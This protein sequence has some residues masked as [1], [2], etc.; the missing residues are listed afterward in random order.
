MLL[1]LPYLTLDGINE[2]GVVISGQNVAGEWVHDPNKI[3]LTA[4]EIR[5]LVLDHAR[6][7]NEA[8][9]LIRQYNN[10]SCEGNKLLVSDA[11]G[12]SAII[13]YFNG[14]VNVIRSQE[15]WQVSTNFLVKYEPPDSV[16]DRC[17]RYSNAYLALQGYNG[18]IT[19]PIAMDILSS[20]YN[21][22]QRSAVYNQTTGKV[23]LCVGGKYGQLH[24]LR[25]PLIVDLAVVKTKVS[26]DNV[27]VGGHMSLA[28]KVV[29]RS[30]RPSRATKVRFYVS[31]KRKLNAQA[32]L[33]GTSKLSS[34]TYRKKETVRLSIDLPEQITAGKYFLI[35]CVDESG[36]NNDPNPENNI[37]ILTD[38]ILVY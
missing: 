5:R 2:Y 27:S 4:L 21:Y 15:P 16:L 37:F 31:K 3:S 20:V 26:D 30:P 35:I 6:D 11:Y 12:N 28:A 14:Q 29:N 8:V 17:W 33:I 23:T 19:N 32:I 38:K 25:L 9:A 22:T 13:E 24:R 7:L 36:R 34:L 10:L 1:S 18:L